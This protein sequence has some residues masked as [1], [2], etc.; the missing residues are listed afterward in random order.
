MVALTTH[1]A[2][3]QLTPRMHSSRRFAVTKQGGA[4]TKGRPKAPQ[5]QKFYSDQISLPI[6]TAVSAIRFEK[7]HSLSYQVRIRT[8]S[9]VHHLGLIHVEDGGMRVVVE[10]RRDILADP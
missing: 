4:I 6:A 1:N 7:P 3:V 8:R 5:S 10:V 2:A 9:A